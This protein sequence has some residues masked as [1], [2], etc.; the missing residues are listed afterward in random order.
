MLAGWVHVL[1]TD[2]D[3]ADNWHED[4]PLVFGRRDAES[5]ARRA[6]VC[7][8]GDARLCAAHASRAS[9]R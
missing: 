2:I 6:G 7:F 4:F 9:I 8:A 3:V 5:C 1:T